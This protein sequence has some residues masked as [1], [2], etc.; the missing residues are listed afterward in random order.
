MRR[1]LTPGWQD[2]GLVFTSL[3][4]GPMQPHQANVELTRAPR[5]AALPLMWVH[6]LRHTAATV[7]LEAGV[8]PKVVQ[9]LLGHKTIATTLDTYSDVMP[10]LHVQAVRV[11]DQW[12]AT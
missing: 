5:V 1:L 7:M 3:N 9:D 8:H 11:L 4:G 10:A 2:S 6:D 12:L